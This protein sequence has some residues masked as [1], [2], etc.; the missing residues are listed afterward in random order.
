M[1]E[2]LKMAQAGDRDGDS[3]SWPGSQAAITGVW[4]TKFSMSSPSY[5]HS[6]RSDKIFFRNYRASAFE[7]SI[8]KI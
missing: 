2:E 6:N 4:T 1:V 8:L 5:C 3:S 7:I